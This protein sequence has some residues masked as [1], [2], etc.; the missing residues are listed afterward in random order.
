[1][2]DI[3]KQIRSILTVIANQFWRLIAT[4][5][6]HPPDLANNPALEDDLKWYREFQPIHWLDYSVVLKHAEN[7]Y[8]EIRD[9]NDAV[10][11]KCEWLFTISTAASY[12]LYGLIQARGVPL[13]AGIPSLFFFGLALLGIIRVRMPGVRPTP[14]A[15]RSA[16]K[17][18]E[19]APNI[20]AWLCASHH[21]AVRELG[22]VN[23]WKTVQAKN[24]LTCVV[25]ATILAALVFIY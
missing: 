20:T 14:M 13:L 8:K 3:Q 6:R 7:K 25:V 23:Q 9:I 19:K 11:K 1:M 15:V 24:S 10:D 4:P 18:G 21:I 12:G 5:F 17:Q 2:P 22:I 16:I